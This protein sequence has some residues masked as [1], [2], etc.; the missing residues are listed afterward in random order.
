MADHRLLCPAFVQF[1]GT[2]G[3][4][5]TGGVVN[6]WDSDER[7]KFFV[8]HCCGD[9][10]R[11]AVARASGAVSADPVIVPDWHPQISLTIRRETDYSCYTPEQ[12]ED[13]Q[14]AVKAE[15]GRRNMSQKDLADAIGYTSQSAV[16]QALSK[17]PKTWVA[18]GI[19]EFLRI[20]I[21]GEKS[22]WTSIPQTNTN[23][24]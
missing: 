16:S 8:R 22:E 23:A 18:S 5:C 13:W 15:L 10:K 3:I 2:R 24:E 19:A 20:P 12:I 7:M 4:S 1:C 9:R 21:G 14:N 11:C 17:F 6:L